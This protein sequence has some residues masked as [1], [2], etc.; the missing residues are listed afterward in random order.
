MS[1]PD[2]HP[3][4]LASEPWDT[5][6]DPDNLLYLEGVEREHDK[7]PDMLPYEE[8]GYMLHGMHSHVLDKETIKKNKALYYGMMSFTDKYIGKILDHLD[9]LE[10]KGNTIIVFTSDHGHLFGQHDMHYKGRFI[11]KIYLKCHLSCDILEKC[12]LE[13]RQMRCNRLLMWRRPSSGL[14]AK[15]YLDG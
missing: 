2:P 4:Y 9:A 10:I 15:V 12:R 6:Y 8:T 7:N 1:F 3:P 5:M 11:M 14:L 13:K